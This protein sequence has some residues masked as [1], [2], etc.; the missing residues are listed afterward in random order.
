MAAALCANT[1]VVMGPVWTIVLLDEVAS[2][3]A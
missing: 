3:I 1:A 2:S